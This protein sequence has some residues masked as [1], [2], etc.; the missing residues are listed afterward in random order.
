[1]TTSPSD[2]EPHAGDGVRPIYPHPKP[3][4]GK[5]P[6]PNRTVYPDG[7][8]VCKGPAWEQRRKE[9][10][11]R[12]GGR[13]DRCNKP[14]PLHGEFAGDAHHTRDRRGLGGGKRWDNLDLLLWLCPGLVGCH[15]AEHVPQ[16]A[17][18]KKE[19]QWPTTK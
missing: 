19:T 1:M 3:P 14:A 11:D 18:P 9:C 10:H 4:R 12:A 2:S 8:E 15:A 16:K 5:H 13:C 17:V 7:R 6:R